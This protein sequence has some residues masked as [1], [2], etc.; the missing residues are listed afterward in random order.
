M[1]LLRSTRMNTDGTL[2][3]KSICTWLQSSLLAIGLLM[4]TSGELGWPIAADSAVGRPPDVVGELTL[5][6]R[7]PAAPAFWGDE[8]GALGLLQAVATANPSQQE[9]HA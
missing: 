4:V 8:E 2:G 6:P 3:A 5:A 1:L 7:A 9:D